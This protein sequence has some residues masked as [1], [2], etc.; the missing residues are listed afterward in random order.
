MGKFLLENGGAGISALRR[1]EI[2][3]PEALPAKLV[4]QGSERPTGV[5]GGEYRFQ[6]GDLQPAEGLEKAVQLLFGEMAENE[7][8][9]GQG[10]WVG[11]GI[12]GTK[13]LSQSGKGAIQIPLLHRAELQALDGAEGGELGCP[14][15]RLRDI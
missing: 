1:V 7:Q 9:F 15:G 14:G 8:R 6:A 3:Q 11:E 5:G 4:I 12:R 10:F 13:P 2:P